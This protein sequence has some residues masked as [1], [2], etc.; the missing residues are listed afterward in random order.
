MSICLLC[1]GLPKELKSAHLYPIPKSGGLRI[2][3]KMRPITLLEIG[4]KLTTGW[5][6][7]KIRLRAATAPHPI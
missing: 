7:Y 3:S 2:F 5:L 1:E 6:A 4:Y